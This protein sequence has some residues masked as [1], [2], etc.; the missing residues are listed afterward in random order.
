[1]IIR[2]INLSLRDVLIKRK[3]LILRVKL[4]HVDTLSKVELSESCKIIPLRQRIG[5]E[6]R[7]R[8]EECY[9]YRE[10]KFLL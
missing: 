3:A 8:K 10:G 1:M 6:L 5:A 2:L 4:L 9:R 7:Q